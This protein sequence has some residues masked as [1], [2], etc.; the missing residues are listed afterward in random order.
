MKKIQSIRFA[1]MCIFCVFFFIES[2][3]FNGTKTIGTS[4]AD[5]TSI[6][7]ALSAANTG[8]LDGP[9]ILSLQA[10]YNSSA[11]TFPLILGNIAG[12]SATNTITIR[13]ASTGLSITSNNTTATIDI[14][15][16]K[17]IIIDGRVN[18]IGSTK[19]LSIA[20]TSTATG[21]AAIR[22]I[23]EANNNTIKYAKI[24]SMFGS[25]TLGVI[26]F[27]TTTGI[28]GNDNNT[29][30]N[31]DID[32][33]AGASASPTGAGA[34]LNG[35]YSVG[36]TTSSTHYN[37]SNTISNCNIF[38]FFNAA[39]GATSSGVILGNGNSDWSINN[40]HFY[41]TATRT[42]T[43]T[44][45]IYVIYLINTNGNNFTINNN[46]IGGSSASA[47]GSA[48][49]VN[50]GFLNTFR[51]MS[52]SVGTSSTSNVQGN[53]ITNINFN[54]SNGASTIPGIFTGIHLITGSF[55][56]GTSNANII[57]ANSGTGAIVSTASLSGAITYG[58]ALES[59]TTS[60]SISNNII[61]AISTNGTSTSI[62]NSLTG[63]ASS[64][65]SSS[66]SI[67]GNT[68]GSTTT[69]NSIYAS[70]AST[71]ST[72]QVVTGIHTS[73][74]G[75]TSIT[76]NTIAN[77]SNAYNPSSISATLIRGIINT[78]GSATITGN[79]IRNL[80]TAAN[81]IGSTSS[82]S[83]IGIINTSNTGSI[84]ISQ[85]VIHSLANTN[86]SGLTAV[87]GICNN[88]P[89][90]GTNTIGRNFIHS[91]KLSTSAVG[92]IYG[93][94]II[95]GTANYQ[96]NMIRLGLDETGASLSNAYSIRGINDNTGS[97]S[98]YFNSI[99]IGGTGVSSGSTN[100]YALFSNVSN[101]RRIVKNNILVNNRSNT[102]GTG[103]NIAYSVSGTLPSLTGLSSNYNVF[104]AN[105][106][107]GT[108]IRHST[109]NYTLTAWRTASN[110]DASS[111]QG[112]PNF[113]LATGTSSTVDLHLQ[114]TSV[115]E[116]NGSAIDEISED[117]DGSARS[118]L[119][120]TDIGADAGTYTST[121][122]SPVNISYAT[123]QNSSTS[124]KVLSNFAIITDNIG[125]SVTS[126]PRLY[127]KKSTENDAFVGNTNASNGWKYVIAS[128][129]SSPYSF[130]IDYSLLNS[131]IA[132]AD[133]I[134]YFL[135]AQDAANNFNSFPE[136]AST[137][138]NPPVENVTAKPSSVNS[139]TITS[140]SINGTLNVGT[141]ESYTS[142]TG[143]G[144]LFADI[145]TK[146]VTGNITVN[147]TSDLVEDGT[148]S[149]NA[150]GEEPYGSNF[151]I[152]IQSNT[153]AMR[154]ISGTSVAS[155][156]PM[157]NFNGTDH[158]LIDGRNAGS[159]QYLS[160]RNTNST[161]A[162]TGAVIQFNNGCLNATL[163][164]CIIES[165][166]SSSSLGAITLGSSGA[167]TL[168]LTN[169]DIRDATA[170]T[171]GNAAIG[172]YSN[173][174]MNTLTATNNSI[175]NFSSLGISL[176]GVNDGCTVN[177]NSFY[178]TSSASA[179]QTSISIQSGG[180]HTI[181][182]NYIGGNTTNA[183]G[184]AWTN[185]GAI[186]FKGI[187]TAGSFFS[188]N[189][190]QNNIIQNINLSNTSTVTFAGIE[191][192]SGLA[193]V[194]TSTGNT[195]GHSTNSNSITVAGTSSTT[196]ILISSAADC[197]VSNN[198]IANVSATG[199]GTGTNFKGINVTGNGTA[200]ISSNTIKNIISNGTSTSE[201]SGLCGIVS[202]SPS[203]G[204]LISK[205]HIYNIESS[206]ASA[207]TFCVGILLN[208]SN[209]NLTLSKNKIYGLTNTSSSASAG[210]YGILLSRG[211]STL[212]N[213]MISI[214]NGAY[215]NGPIISGI[216]ENS[217]T[218]TT[219]TLY[220]NS[221][222]I[223]GT[224]TTSANSSSFIRI[225]RSI[226]TI[227]DNIFINERSGG[228]GK[229]Y[230]IS[231]TT[232]SPSTGWSSSASDYN[233]LYSSTAA[234]TG[235]WTVDQ[236]FAGF[237]SASAGDAN[238]KNVDVTFN[239]EA[240]GDL[241]I[242]GASIGS[243]NLRGT[244]VASITEDFDEQ[245]RPSTSGIPYI[246]ADEVTS[247]PLPIELLTFEGSAKT[248]FNA[249]TWTTASEI[250]SNYFEVERLNTARKFEPIGRIS[251]AGNSKEINQY[252]FHDATF[253]TSSSIQYYRLKMIDRDNQF[254]FSDVIAVKRNAKVKASV[255]LYPNPSSETLNIIISNT[256][257]TKIQIKILDLVGKV[258]YEN[259]NLMSNKI[260]SIETVHFPSGMYTLQVIGLTENI[261]QKFMKK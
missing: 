240:N 254:S 180:N 19:D 5:Y 49:T 131:T 113:V 60:T 30:D 43:G 224:A 111:H 173:N 104:F 42:P 153:N 200:T 229:H 226:V 248:D 191:V 204:Q 163:R 78:A 110:Q 215:S 203:S 234:T 57:G 44:V 176:A 81:G 106:T 122:G 193:Q 152:T 94:E 184:S 174:T 126:K 141:G 241:H 12:I 38:D 34:A 196:G 119:S 207:S 48:W 143:A 220:Y 54:T 121:D 235:Y 55:N 160:F 177:G 230:A 149:L 47:E 11:E 10:D 170:G 186:A 258:V 65:T 178:A 171:V 9:V 52:L 187:T 32:G 172:I 63:I 40:N 129:S 250:N 233:I 202:S 246:G 179:A 132:N 139:Y 166:A 257:A 56:V 16:G 197:T 128:N 225:V 8:V 189:S 183:G 214:T 146:I 117:Y 255:S 75:I 53:I 261:N 77:L 127:F 72:A 115:A 50:G 150:L 91:L 223:G 237:Q 148:N 245:V 14:N 24:S 260:N 201:L 232:S 27:S 51:G 84:T 118:G 6:T 252:Q 1:W 87:L 243:A 80:S 76:N 210:V 73:G 247:N 249:L 151:S 92:T 20:N 137:N 29:I 155:G 100:T 35:V 46:Y 238:T 62:S 2:H 228:T 68:I 142:L 97:N 23:N 154:T 156:T 213:N 208:A 136:G 209:G 93:I 69:A 25:S 157:I 221:V 147:I 133:V 216:H 140:S 181:N 135:V 219:H 256:D 158:I 85:N 194:G 4:G 162:N 125:V 21:G 185:T 164:N 253:N 108:L 74:A 61:A 190:I 144:G 138:A 161:A 123:I 105:G 114:G 18:G 192:S 175:Y 169:N 66:I 116:G 217:T 231:N 15:E 96:N 41:Q 236:T 88:G 13:P 130:T 102:S 107:G 28:A 17:Y 218:S 71:H 31:C 167:N 205:N 89:N 7:S 99:Y 159:G 244:L 259:N 98:F 120:A 251:A 199:T 22:F 39:P 195:I 211:N 82:S 67:S 36:T 212:I 95:G 101:S 222:R 182:N 59:T 70:N 90:S 124:N 83:V 165:N 109:T 64:S 33:K 198:L 134:E 37:S 188:T 168:T 112:D 206:T 79:T 45:L 3:A 103:L 145:N 26:T 239:D 227:K 86:T 242:A 58:I